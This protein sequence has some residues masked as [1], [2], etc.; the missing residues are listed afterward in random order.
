MSDALTFDEVRIILTA[1]ALW[2]GRSTDEATLSTR[3]TAVELV[4]KFIAFSEKL[5]EEMLP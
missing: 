2:L 1:F 3:C 4:D 5:G